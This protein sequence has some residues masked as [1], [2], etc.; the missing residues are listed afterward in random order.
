MPNGGVVPQPTVNLPPPES[1]A[2]KTNAMV[3]VNPALGESPQALNTLAQVPASGHEIGGATKFL[4]A[5]ADFKDVTQNHANNVPHAGN[6]WSDV[7]NFAS[8]TWNGL[9][10]MGS[11]ALHVVNR[12]AGTAAELGTLGLVGEHGLGHFSQNLND[13]SATVDHFAHTALN[14]MQDWRLASRTYAYWH[15]Q[16]A[17]HGNAYTAGE[18]LPMF[19]SALMGGEVLDSAGIAT[20]VDAGRVADTAN[21]AKIDRATAAGTATPDMIAQRMAIATRQ[22]RRA[23]L[24]NQG[25]LSIE[26]MANMVDQKSAAFKAAFNTSDKVSQWGPG[27]AIKG[28]SQALGGQLGGLRTNLLYGLTATHAAGAPENQALWNNPYVQQGIPIDAQVRPTASNF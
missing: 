10:Q 24:D 6:W 18:L 5:G 12:V 25:T 27:L 8:G 9:K 13:A 23:A 22:I 4:T 21:L 17:R 28:V 11:G 20:G 16:S 7:T 19:A 14:P 1:L 2:D 26:K 3:K 15:S